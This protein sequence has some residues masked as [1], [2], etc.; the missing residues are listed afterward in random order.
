MVE[1]RAPGMMV[2]FTGVNSVSGDSV[3][4]GWFQTHWPMAV[5]G[6]A[7][8]SKLGTLNLQWAIAH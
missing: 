2:H 5:L 8:A 6:T 1:G 4:M 3:S 7:G